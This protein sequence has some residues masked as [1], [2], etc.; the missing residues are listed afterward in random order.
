MT[1]LLMLLI[2]IISFGVGTATNP[3]PTQCEAPEIVVCEPTLKREFE[4]LYSID[5][6]GFDLSAQAMYGCQRSFEHIFNGNVEGV[7]EETVLFNK[8]AEEVTEVMNQR[9]YLYQTA[10]EAK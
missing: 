9:E 5:N 3:E 7:E 10:T 8:I 2:S 1:V 6:K 4:Q